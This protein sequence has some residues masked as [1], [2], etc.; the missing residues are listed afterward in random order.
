[1]ISVPPQ[2]ARNANCGPLRRPA[3]AVILP[4]TARGNGMAAKTL[5]SDLDDLLD[6]CQDNVFK[7]VFARD[8]EDSRRA[9]SGLVSAIIGR[10]LEV[11]GILANEPP[12]E[13]AR[14]R[15]IRF[16]INCRAGDGEPIDVEM[17]LNPDRFEPVRLEYY[18]ARLFVSQDIRG[19]AK[20]YDDLKRTYQIAILAK[21]TFFA[22]GDFL[23]GFEYY[24]PARAMP[25][26]GRTR[27]FTVE[28]SKLEEVARK[29]VEEMSN[30]EFWAMF[31]RYHK[32]IA[33]RATI[34][35]IAGME[36]GI[37]MAGGALL[38]IS[39]DEEQ[40]ARLESEY[41]GAVDFQSKMVQ[42]KRDGLRE[43]EKKRDA[44]LLAFIAKGYTLDDIKRELEAQG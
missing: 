38:N 13:S 25:L 14:D 2:N 10:E 30:A 44:E 12:P 29:P 7:A 43:G 42:A 27:I 5:F 18:A 37:A 35:R 21:G 20:T 23:H 8:A 4:D 24:D 36:E 15:L 26:G 3:R 16:D 1:L 40:R 39:R 41:K 9:L 28:L 33:M 22:D 11:L 19:A 31:F 6:I 17:C 32:D 34:N